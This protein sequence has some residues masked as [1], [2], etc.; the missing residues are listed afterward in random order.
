MVNSNVLRAAGEVFEAHHVTIRPGERMAETVARALHISEDKA[1]QWLAALD[2]GATAEQANLRAG[3]DSER[4][5][6]PVLVALARALGKFAG[7]I[8]G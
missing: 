1:E 3:M 6:E 7:S 5:Q 2:E 8:T 4:S